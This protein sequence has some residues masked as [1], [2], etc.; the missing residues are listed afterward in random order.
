MSEPTFL[1]N[2]KSEINSALDVGARR[3]KETN[4]FFS[5]MFS[6]VQD[7]ATDL[8]EMIAR[9]F[10]KPS[11][12]ASAHEMAYAEGFADKCA[13]LGVDVAEL[14]KTSAKSCS[15]PAAPKPPVK[16]IKPKPPKPYMPNPHV[17][18]IKGNSKLRQ[19][20]NYKPRSSG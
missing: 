7:E 16:K 5:R 3:P 11:K 17:P 20:S 1:D 13:D 10:N 4:P 2:L 18:P 15:T 8:K 14:L 6:N 9:L 12:E 19:S